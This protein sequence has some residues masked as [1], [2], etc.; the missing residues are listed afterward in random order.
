MLVKILARTYTWK[1]KWHA[2]QIIRKCKTTS[3]LTEHYVQQTLLK[4]T[5][6]TNG[7]INT[8]YNYYQS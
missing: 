6:E 2:R 7:R 8:G 3:T 4:I 5:D 1:D